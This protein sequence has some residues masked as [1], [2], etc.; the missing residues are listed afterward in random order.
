MKYDPIAIETRKLFAKIKNE[1]KDGRKD[2]VHH[3]SGTLDKR[4]RMCEIVERYRVDTKIDYVLGV[5]S[6]EEYELEIEAIAKLEL[7]VITMNN[8]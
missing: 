5:I 4:T 7:A 8:Y 1:L 6:R 3:I 2:F